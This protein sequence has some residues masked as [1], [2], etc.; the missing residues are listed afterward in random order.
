VNRVDIVTIKQ[1]EKMIPANDGALEMAQWFKKHA[2]EITKQQHED[3]KLANTKA[4][5]RFRDLNKH[6]ATK[7]KGFGDVEKSS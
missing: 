4:K 3:I 5:K 6:Y 1:L 2:D 7:L